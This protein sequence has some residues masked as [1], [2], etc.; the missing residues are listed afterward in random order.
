LF[1]GANLLVPALLQDV[2][3]SKSTDAPLGVG[4]RHLVFGLNPLIAVLREHKIKIE[5]LL[6]QSGISRRILSNPE[7]QLEP[8]KELTFWTLASHELGGGAIGLELGRRYHCSTYGVLGLAILTSTNLK[9]AVETIFE[10]VAMT[11]TFFALRCS[12]ARGEAKLAF[13]RERDLGP[14]FRFMSDRGI[15]AAYT[16]FS[17][18]LGEYFPL[19]Y[20]QFMYDAPQDRQLYEDLFQCPVHFARD[21]NM[22][23]FDEEWMYRRLPQAEET[24]HRIFSAQC[25][26]VTRSLAAKV[27]FSE[28]VRY[29]LL[30]DLARYSYLENIAKT[31]SLSPRTIQRKLSREKTSFTTLVEE[32]RLNLSLEYLTGT[33]L[34]VGEVA[35]RLGYG[36]TA[37]FS[38]AFT[39]WVGK[40]PSD[41]RNQV[42]SL[43]HPA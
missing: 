41:Y 3:W 31:L 37:S 43:S 9:Q 42:H 18:A 26:D 20:V 1:L 22:L 30:Q 2:M 19:R 21:C 5:P 34:P 6:R 27:R 40:S 39:R 14:L 4:M 24:T 23:C 12:I 11:W 7:S 38:H 33:H 10:N 28:I 17:E 13:I 25:R 15:T 32:V 36:D 8:D 16:M 29:N 35:R